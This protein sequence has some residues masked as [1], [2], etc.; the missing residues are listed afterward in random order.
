M[1]NWKRKLASRKFWAAIIGV[2]SAIL[3]L[4]QVD[5]LT[6]ERIAALISA[7]GALIAFILAEG[8]VD[9]AAV[10]SK[11]EGQDGGE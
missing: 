1:I 10:I 8:S 9:K 5:A 7:E 3:V 11:K 2:V 6:A 4:V